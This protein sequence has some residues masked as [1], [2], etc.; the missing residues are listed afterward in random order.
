MMLAFIGGPALDRSRARIASRRW[1]WFVA[2]FAIG[3]LGVPGGA[4]EPSAANQKKLDWAGL[5]ALL[6]TGDYESAVAAA[7]GI[8]TQLEPDRRDRDFVARSIGFV[9]A[10]MRRGLAELRLGQLD[11]AA[12]SFEEAYRSLK[13]SNFKRL[14]AT[15]AR[16][17]NAQAKNTLVLLDLTMIELL[18]LRMAVLVD[19]LRFLN[20]GVQP[21]GAVMPDDEPARRELVAEWLK[22][23]AFLEKNA[24]DARQALAER[25]GQASQT[26]LGSPH[27]QS[28]AG[29]FRPSMLAG[30]KAL[31][32]GRLPFDPAGESGLK[33]P[34]AADSTIDQTVLADAKR[35]FQE[36]STALAKA[37]EAASPK[38][39]VAMKPAERVEAALLRAELLVGEGRVLLA[40]GDPIGAR[41]CFAKVLDLRREASGLL[42]LPKPEEHP[43]LFVPLLL[44]AEANVQLARTE[45]QAGDPVRAR[46]SIDEATKLLSQAQQLPLPAVHPLHKLAERVQAMI[47]AGTSTVVAQTPETD[48]ADAAARRLRRALDTTPVPGATLAP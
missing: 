24:Q 14:I 44:A 46:G 3:W 26:V 5:D 22:D 47:A 32:L 11:A 37:I 41:A 38:G 48:A 39:A 42:K 13:D 18:E 7:G 27:Y 43:D 25:F 31:E 2:A 15:E 28:L 12:G 17:P 10:M 45:I 30:T 35:F 9:R 21:L 20:F 40:A 29:T 33:P 4:A 23:L 1:L 19:R 8:A 36:A 16:N 6:A 34:R